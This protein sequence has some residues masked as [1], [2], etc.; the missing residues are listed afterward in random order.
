MHLERKMQLFTHRYRF[1]ETKIFHRYGKYDND[2]DNSASDDQNVANRFKPT[3]FQ[4][5]FSRITRTSCEIYSETTCDIFHF[6]QETSTSKL[7]KMLLL[8]SEQLLPLRPV[9]DRRCARVAEPCRQAVGWGRRVG[10]GRV[11][12]ESYYGSGTT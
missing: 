11:V 10:S 4:S 1:K 8:G 2:A 5:F 9:A 6:R 7:T 12:V 3:D